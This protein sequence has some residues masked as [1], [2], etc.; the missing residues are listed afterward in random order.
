VSKI[1]TS[2]FSGD[3]GGVLLFYIFAAGE[4]AN[5]DSLR[6][7]VQEGD[8]IIAADG[9]ALHCLALKL[10]PD[11]VIG[12]FD[13][14]R[15]PE[16][17]QLKEAGSQFKRFPTHKDFTDLELAFQYAC[18]LGAQEIVVLG[19]FGFRWDQTLA[20]LLLLVSPELSCRSIR[21]VD[22][23]QE[24]TLIRAGTPAEVIG[25]PGDIVSLIPVSGDAVGITTYGLEYPLNNETLTFGKARGVSNVLLN[26]KAEISLHEGLLIC[27]VIHQ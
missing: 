4:L 12:D 5:P 7:S 14:L 15:E 27:I 24:V 9:G 16:I 23:H 20:N 19:A 18:E 1:S 13:S 3:G 6:I 11:I 21:F 8:K 17:L 10:I 25:Q 26:T 22:N 2:T